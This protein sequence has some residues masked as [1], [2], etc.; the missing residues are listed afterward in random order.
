MGERLSGLMLLGLVLWTAVGAVGLL[1]ARSRGETRRFRRG[2]G[3]LIAIWVGYMLVLVGVSLSQ[4]GRIYEPGQERC[5]GS[6]CFAVTGVE[7]PRGFLVRGEDPE[8]LIRVL[9]RMQNRDRQHTGS[10]EGLAASLIDDQGRRWQPVPG[11]GGVR[12]ATPIAAGRSTTSE[13]VFRPAKEATGLRLVLEHTSWTW[14]R[15]KIGDPES[16]FHRPAEMVVR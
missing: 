3:T 6:M 16:Y 10:E 12:L 5:F 8:R 15:L 11:L 7:E 13:P 2:A 9:V 4:K 1:L 14:A